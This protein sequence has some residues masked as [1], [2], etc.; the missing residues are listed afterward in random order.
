VHDASQTMSR[1]T[2]ARQAVQEAL[3]RVDAAEAEVHA[4]VAL[5]DH[6][7]DDADAVDRRAAA[8][9]GTLPL[10]GLVVGVKDI[11]D[12]AGLPTRCGSE[13]TTSPA[14][15]ASSAPC[16]RRL[17][18]LGAV[19]LGKTVTTEYGYFAPGPT[20]NPAAPGHTPGGSSS[21]SAAAV[22][23]GMVP[24]A[25]GTQ[26]AGSLTRPAAY[27]G[28]T[29]MVLAHGSTDTSGITGLSESLDSLGLVTR[30]VDDLAVVY[31]AFA[32]TPVRTDGASDVDSRTGPQ[33]LLWRPRLAD[34]LDPL[35]ERA[36]KLAATLLAGS[37]VSAAPLEWDDH[38]RT[39]LADHPVIMAHEA[40]R[41]RAALLDRPDDISAPL[42]DLLSAGAAITPEE[43]HDARVRLDVSRADLGTL[44]AGGRVVLGPAALGPA[45]AGL[46]ATGSPVLSR[47]WQAL[48]LPVVTVPG[49]RSAH[50]L[51][52]GLQVI[53][54]PGEEAA[55]F[56]VAA[57]L[58][59]LVAGVVVDRDADL[60]APH[61][62]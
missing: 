32:G 53:G 20:D 47:P 15:T 7:L 31:E 35:M 56:A 57:R 17:E 49:L 13:P 58:E 29:G 11:I 8:H 5:S 24:L 28:V 52:L 23:A 43:H 12:V 42:R 38:V 37:G 26:T 40:A 48:G 55:L 61:A 51:P 21:G 22:A 30:T 33:V 4:W 34:P 50:G 14:P 18:D 9:P 36:L 44:L 59:S 16:V 25:L 3:S 19:V 45:P 60:P 27:C 10:R 41:Q 54:L 46:A 2:S 1:T 6:A 62:H 39:L